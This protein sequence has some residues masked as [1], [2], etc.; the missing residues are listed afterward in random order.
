M[1]DDIQISYKFDFVARSSING[2]E[3]DFFLYHDEILDDS[4]KNQIIIAINQ[5]IQKELDK[6]NGGR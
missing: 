4:V 3:K 1:N 6:K 5:A 2:I